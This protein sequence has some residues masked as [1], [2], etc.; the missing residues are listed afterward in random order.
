ML[1]CSRTINQENNMAKGTENSKKEGAE[2]QSS[3]QNPANGL[4]FN[5][6]LMDILSNEDAINPYI[7]EF[8]NLKKATPDHLLLKLGQNNNGAIY[9]VEK[10]HSEPVKRNFFG[11]ILNFALDLITPVRNLFSFV[12][13]PG[14]VQVTWDNDQL[15]IYGAGRHK[16]LSPFHRRDGK[17]IAIT[18]PPIND[19]DRIISLGKQIQIINVPPGR[20]GV[21][22]KPDGSYEVLG[23]GTHVLEGS[24]YTYQG[25]K[26]LNP[27]NGNYRIDLGTMEL[28]TIPQDSLGLMK[29]NDGA[30]KLLK[31]GRHM[32][33]KG[34]QCFIEMK[35][36]ND[37]VVKLEPYTLLNVRYGKKAEIYE[38]NQLKILSAGLHLIKAPYQQF[39]Q[40]VDVT[41]KDYMIGTNRNVTVYSGEVGI[42][43]KD[44]KLAILEP[45]RYQLDQ[46]KEIF[47]GFMSTQQQD[48]HYEMMVSTKDLVD[49]KLKGSVFFRVTDPKKIVEKFG[50]MV[51]LLQIITDRTRGLLT[52]I[53]RNHDY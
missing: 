34:K 52:D 50:N 47:S 39:N 18:P 2:I 17:P 1:V 8:S 24:G 27:S 3:V 44:G 5:N 25:S 11:S 14:H 7:G 43:Y 4:I 15:I 26:E 29:T 45:G 40:I 22:Q 9:N 35:K 31:P 42:A 10:R 48:H 51:R 19:P 32:L 30:F 49:I 38:N 28:I 53:F 33:T 36:I 21:A 41:A 37:E 12:V 13:Q 20:Y 6:S 46:T 16:L 23:E